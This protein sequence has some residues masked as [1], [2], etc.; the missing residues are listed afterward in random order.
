[1][2]PVGWPQ[3]ALALLRS[4]RDVAP[5]SAARRA[6]D[7]D[8]LRR[9]PRHHRDA[10]ELRASTVV[11][12]DSSAWDA[13][14]AALP[15]RH[16]LFTTEARHYVDRLADVVP[17]T[18]SVRV[19]DFGCGV[20]LAA[21]LLA[22]RVGSVTAW[23]RSAAMRRLAARHLRGIGNAELRDPAGE[24]G[25]ALDRW[26]LVLVNSVLQYMRPVQAAEWLPRWRAWLA[27][28]GR[29]VVSDVVTDGG[30]RGERFRE[31]I[32]VLVFHARHGGLRRA[33]YERLSDVV[34]YWRAA[35]AAPLTR[36]DRDTLTRIAA[37]AGLRAEILPRNLTCRP[38]R[39]AAV[40]TAR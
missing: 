1:M 11:A 3:R 23:D 16:V 37:A 28:A 12:D 31:A 17:L 39:L 10:R 9:L 15:C 8:G 33:A 19:L 38:R 18:P 2:P 4:S 26:D 24:D 20:G 32:D 5:R 35:R 29:L 14:W 30:G 7:A 40:L 34:R 6:R 25:A 27:P 22:A 36:F 21:A 13:Y